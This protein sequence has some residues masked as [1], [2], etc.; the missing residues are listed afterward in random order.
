MGITTH[1]GTMT[2]GVTPTC[3]ECGIS[4]CWDI[5]RTEYLS[6]KV[7]WDAWRCQ[8]CNGFR[9][10]VRG[11]QERNGFE[12]LPQAVQSAVEAFCE[13]HPDFA[14]A[15]TDLSAEA[16]GALAVHLTALGFAPRVHAIAQVRGTDHVVVEIDGIS[17]D[18]CAGGHEEDA[19]YPLGFRTGLGWPVTPATTSELLE[20]IA[21]LAPEELD[22]LIERALA[23]KAAREAA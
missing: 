1:G 6:A 5:S 11:W 22:A 4:L 21:A 16:S 13:V 18:L 9:L 7:F 15:G 23:R 2:G 20:S 10:S 12:A 3:S 17:I 8:D 19:P 14:D